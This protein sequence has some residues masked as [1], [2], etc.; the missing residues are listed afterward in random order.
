M[1]CS[2]CGFMHDGDVIGAMNLFK[3]YI[4]DVGGR[5]MC[6]PKSAHDLHAEWLVATMKRR[7]RHSPS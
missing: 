7:Q 3:R 5:A 1:K 2:E 4:L 6:L